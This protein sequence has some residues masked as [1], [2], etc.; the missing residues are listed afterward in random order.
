MTMDDGTGSWMQ[1]DAVG[2]DEAAHTADASPADEHLLVDSELLLDADQELAQADASSDEDDVAG[3][4]EFLAALVKAVRATQT[5]AEGNVLI[6]QFVDAAAQRMATL[7]E[8]TDHVTLAVDEDRFVCQD[9]PV[10]A[11]EISPTN[12][13]FLFFRNGIRVISFL[14]GFEREQLAEFV[15]II[16]GGMRGSDED[17]LATLWH[18]DLDGFQMEYVDTAEDESLELPQPDRNAGEGEAVEDLEEIEEVLATGELP[19]G[20]E[21]AVAAITLSDG[22]LAYLK[23]ELEAEWVRPVARDVTLALLDQFEM[24]DVSRR[25]QVIDILREVLPLQFAKRD[26]GNVALIV[27]ELQL[28]ANKTGDEETQELVTSLLRDMSEAMAELVAHQ[29]AEG[30]GPG[31]EA[32]EVRALADALQGEAIPTLIRAVPAVA[33]LRT[34]NQLMEALDRLVLAHPDSIQELLASQDS[35]L[36]AESARIVGRLTLTSAEPALL[37]LLKRDEPKARQAALEALIEIGSDECPRLLT[38]ALED[39]NRDIRMTAVKSLTKLDPE[40]TATTLVGVVTGHSIRDR[41]ASELMSL[42]KA[43]AEAAGEEAVPVL[44]KLLNKRSWYGG[45]VAPAVRAGAARAL[46]LLHTPAAKKALDKAGKDKEET[47]RN[48]VRVALKAHK[49]AVVSSEDNDE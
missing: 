15:S 36:V 6:T 40:E 25:K 12:L 3:V 16:G 41:E 30:E 39:D 29:P 34:Q 44:A 42:F 28:L 10:Y 17:L 19:P 43:Y 32:D 11:Q 33:N 18:V 37:E 47:V 27:T 4:R 26:F 9:Q 23:R 46:G 2:Q 5:Y 7:W 48:A 45:R 22:D 35:V 8:Q 21:E 31:P 13:A 14:Q 24:R 20:E 38:E 49:H 1:D